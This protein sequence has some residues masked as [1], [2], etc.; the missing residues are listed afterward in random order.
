MAPSVGTTGTIKLLILAIDMV[1]LVPAQP[2][3]DG[4][5]KATR[6]G[7]DELKEAITTHV[8]SV[9]PWTAGAVRIEFCSRLPDVEIAGDDVTYRVTMPR[10]DDFIGY[11]NLGLLFY[12]NEILVKDVNVRIKL[13]VRRDVVTSSRYLAQGTVIGRDDIAVVEKWFSRPAFQVVSKPE[14]VLGKELTTSLRPNAEFTRHVLRDSIV[15]KRGALVR[16]VLERQVL[17]LSTM[18]VSEEDGSKGE[19]IRVKNIS[20]KKVIY[21][22]VVDDSLVAVDF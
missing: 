2:Q 8:E 16:I 14:E 13:E 7:A 12:R 3:A 22:R 17:K 9:M 10:T 18:G 20:S 19:L 21:A 11:T 5:S 4:S 15:V 1:F 6:I